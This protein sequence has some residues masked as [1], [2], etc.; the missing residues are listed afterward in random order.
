MINLNDTSGLPLLLNTQENSLHPAGEITY[1]S[2]DR[3]KLDSIRPILLNKT[4]R[5]PIDIYTEYIDISLTKHESSFKKNDLHYSITLLPPGLLG[6][7]YNKTHIFAPD[8]DENDITAIADIIHGNGI[9]LI[10]RVKEKGELDFDTEV[11]FVAMCRVRKGDRIPVPQKYMYTFLNSSSSTLVIGRL[12][13]DDGKIDYRTI[14]RER[15]MSYYFIRKNARQEIVKNPNYKEV[16]LL[17]RKKSENL[18]RKYKLT[19]S[20]PIYTQFIQNERR[21]RKMLV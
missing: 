10:Q 9:V 7:E 3:V 12:Y 15:G 20:K 14:R 1:S 19:S 6:I 16:P 17:K 2:I 11:E 18:A 21:F 13:E 8:K 5:Y 4:L